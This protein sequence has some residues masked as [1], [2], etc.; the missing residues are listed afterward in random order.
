MQP[1]WGE[2]RVN[3]TS[4]L[5]VQPWK[6]RPMTRW[7]SQISLHLPAF[8]MQ[9]KKTAWIRSKMARITF[10]WEILLLPSLCSCLGWSFPVNRRWPIRRSSSWSPS[11][12]LR[13]ELRLSNLSFSG[14]SGKKKIM[15]KRCLLQARSDLVSGCLL[16]LLAQ[17]PN[18]A[19]NLA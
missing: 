14:K 7:Y 8:L 5:P 3:F 2:S 11:N 16:L 4:L 6:E 10:P 12:C 13:P 18:A 19:V 9:G 17:R 1:D 15:S